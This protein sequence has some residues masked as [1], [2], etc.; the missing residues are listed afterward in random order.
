MTQKDLSL[1]ARLFLGAFLFLAAPPTARPVEVAREILLE[2]STPVQLERYQESDRTGFPDLD[3]LLSR[4]PG[5]AARLALDLPEGRH[6][7]FRKYLLVRLSRE[8]AD[9][10]KAFVRS[11]RKLASVR[12]AQQHRAFATR[13]SPND[14][15][16]QEQWGAV[17]IHAQD[18]WDVTRGSAEIPI[19]V[20]DTG[21]DLMHPDLE[22]SLWTN[23]DEISGN[24]IDDD[25]NGFVDD[26]IG[27]DFV[28]APTFPTSGDYLIRDND[29][30]DE[31][32]HGTAIAGVIGAVMD[33]GIGVAGIAPDCPLMILRAGNANGFLQEDDVASAVLYA[34]DNGARVINMSFG[35]VEASPMLN[36]VMDYAYQ[37]GM[38][39]VAA[40]GNNASSQANYPAAF[41][42]V[43]CI[44]SCDENGE[45]AWDSNYGTTLDFLAP[46]VEIFTTLMGGQYGL[47]PPTGSGTSFAAPHASATAGLVL[48]LHPDWGPTEVISALLSSAEDTGPPGWDLE[49]GHGVLRADRAVEVDEPL[50]ARITYPEMDQGLVPADTLQI[51]GTASGVYLDE[52]QVFIGVGENP[53]TWEPV[54]EP[55]T[56]QIVNGL[57]ATWINESPTDS[58]YTVK[59]VVTDIFGDQV[60]D[61]VLIHFDSTP[62]EISN[63]SVV[64]ILDGERPSYLLTFQTD[65]LTTGKVWLRGTQSAEERWISLSL[66]YE[67]TDHVI[68]I[69]RDLPY[70]EFEYYVWVTNSTGLVDSTDILGTLDLTTPSIT[71]N[72]FVE[73]PVSGIP[74]SFFYE[75]AT[76]LDQDGFLEIWVDTLDEAGGRTNLRVYETNAGGQFVDLGLDYGLEIP[77]SIGDSDADGM[78]EILTLYAGKSKIFE[79]TQ[80]DGFP[81]PVQPYWEDNSGNV[82]GAKLLDL[83]DEYPY[84]EVLLESNGMY[85]LYRNPGGGVLQFQQSLPDPFISDTTTTFPPYCRL[86]DYDQDGKNELLFGDYAGN[87]YIYERQ[88]GGLMELTWSYSL[89]LLDTGEF[90]TDGDYDGDGVPEFAALAHT[91]TQLTGE[92]LADTRYWALYVF[93]NNGDN[94]YIPLDTLYVFGAENPG[95]FFSG[96]ASGDVIGDSEPEIILCLYPDLYVLDWQDETAEFEAIWYYPQCSSNT[97][98]IGDFNRNGRAEFL[99]NTGTQVKAYEEVG[100]WSYWPP[101]PLN[102]HV[103]EVRTDRVTLAWSAVEGAD[104]YNL[105][106]GGSP[107]SLLLLGEVSA[108]ATDT[109]DWDVV[110]DSTYYYAISTVDLSADSIE[111]FPT[112]PLAATPNEAPYVPGDTAHFTPP[113]FVSLQFSEP[114]S[115]SI[116]DVRNYWLNGFEVQPVSAISDA[117]GTRVVLTF[118]YDFS[119]STLCSLMVDVLYDLQGSYYYNLG[120]QSKIM[121]SVPQMETEQAP[122]LVSATAAFKGNIV[123]LVFSAP[124]N[125]EELAIKTN[126]TI[127]VDPIQ[128]LSSPDPII[129]SEAVPDTNAA[130]LVH[131]FLSENTPIGALG[132]IY[133][134]SARNL[135]SLLG[136]PL[137]EANSSATLTFTSPRLRNAFV[138]PNPY[139]S[140]ETVD[141]EDCVVFANLT[142]NCEIRILNLS[143]ILIKTLKTSNNITGGVRWYV[144]NERGEKVGSG[145]Y[146]YQISDE[147][148]TIWGKIAVVR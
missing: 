111:G 34:L 102:F 60:S 33:N 107:E 120:T 146:I 14:P 5:S 77:K 55:A 124:M 86:N 29:P 69:G 7:Q 129:I 52:F 72:D 13:F 12:W 115:E 109:T 40:S 138:Y 53:A 121:F 122:Y 99:F 78:P 135:H 98:L 49:S 18:A 125:Q 148:E 136:V 37:Q 24:G 94:S 81:D 28:D 80:P 42:S 74:P 139:K 96:I 101:P 144:D 26:V 2:V 141:G 10:V 25:G 108:S 63:L 71:S 59:L 145:I 54:K 66:N 4:F 134:V 112:P 1:T 61:R 43:L 103:S 11:A 93:K 83:D 128:S 133:R 91:E 127:A 143:G 9:S 131:L 45:R 70:K 87:L 41:G 38:I 46:G 48:S 35:D 8:Y 36:D 132:K 114:M 89:P 118:D 75:E 17:R 19:A 117:G 51:L 22:S 104:R 88:P 90:L 123:T 31:M 23:D 79:A 32:G 110:L 147:D 82:W 44:G 119:N 76:D 68:L 100:D 84:G 97:A 57:L 65:D 3:A 137:D 142:P 62:P 106:R 50:V 56:Y 47:M 130:Y 30:S 140:G 20:I 126:Y 64:P 105:Y 21:C 39:L 95:D 116:L 92:H 6:P 27:W 16:Y 58:T 67:T 85:H 113:G 15:Y 73:L